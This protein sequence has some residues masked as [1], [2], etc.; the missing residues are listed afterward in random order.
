MGG[1]GTYRVD[2]TAKR[3]RLA[4]ED[5]PIELRIWRHFDEANICR[6][7]VAHLEIEDVAGDNV[8]AGVVLLGAV[9]QQETLFWKHRL[10]RRHD[11]RAGPVCC[12]CE[13]DFTMAVCLG[14]KYLGR[15]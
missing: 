14:P 12:V 3:H 4:G 9:A 11:A 8:G 7:L 10:D 13:H 6:E 15:S 5:G 2:G 1:C